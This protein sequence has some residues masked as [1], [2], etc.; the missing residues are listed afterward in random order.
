MDDARR[1]ILLAEL[2]DARRARDRLTV[3][4]DVL[5]ERV[6]A[7]AT[8][9]GTN[10]AGQDPWRGVDPFGAPSGG[11]VPPSRSGGRGTSSG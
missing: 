8:D 4:I 6:G 11:T 5:S 3:F 7:S 9:A 10:S 1:T 2:D